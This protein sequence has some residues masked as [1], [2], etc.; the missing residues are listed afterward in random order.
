MQHGLTQPSPKHHKWFW[1]L[2]PLNLTVNPSGL[3]KEFSQIP[4][5]PS[6]G[7]HQNN[8]GKWQQNQKEI[9]E[10][11]VLSASEN[12]DFGVETTIIPE[13]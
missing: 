1:I 2:V 5:P 6:Q 13:V 4:L 7:P 9:I 10:Y 11:H 8:G 12:R 3:R